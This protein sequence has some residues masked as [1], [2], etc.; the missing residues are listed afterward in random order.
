M[1]LLAPEWDAIFLKDA[2]AVTKFR[3]VGLPAEVLHEAMNP[4]WHTR[5]FDSVGEEIVVAG[6]YYGYRQYLVACLLQAGAPLAL[7][8]PPPPRWAKDVI[9]QAHRGR[10][11][12][13]E[14]KARLFGAAVACLNSTDLSEGDSLNCRAFEVAGSCGL[15]MIE[16]K[17]AVAQCF[18][19][20]AELLVYNSVTEIMDH[21]ARAR[22]EPDWA[23]SVREA[24]YRRAH[25]HH[26]YE[27]R[28]RAILMGLGL[29]K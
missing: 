28:L 14:E 9:K 17:P 2:A 22:R 15:L 19:P 27:K 3:A 8:G 16:N 25:A 13:R 7:Y 10:Y 4:A 20:G 18:E 26:T 23:M 11:V 21:I 24:G 5:S 1:G 12:A 29:A 6:S